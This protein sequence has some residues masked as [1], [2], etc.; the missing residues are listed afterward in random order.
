MPKHPRLMKRGSTFWHRAAVPADIRG[1]YPKTEE[2]FSLKTKDPRAAL[3]LVRKAAAEVDERFASHRR[4]LTR[5]DAQPVSELTAAQVA[6]IEELYFAHLLDEDDEVRLEGFYEKDGLLPEDP[7]PSFEG[8]AEG[9][10]EFGQD[11]RFMIARGK[12]DVSYR[13]EVEEVLGWDGLEIKLEPASSSWKLATRALQA[14]IVRAQEVIA[15]R[16]VGDLVP[17]P[18]VEPAAPKAAANHHLG[19]IMASAVRDEWLAEKSKVRWV[20]KTLH[21]HEVWTQHFLALVGDR[22]IDSYGKADGRAFRQALQRLPANWSKNPSLRGLPFPQ[23]VARAGELSLPPMS[24]KNINKLMQFVGSMWIWAE[25][26]YDEVTASPFKGQSIEITARAR[27]ERDPFSTDQLNKIFSPRNHPGALDR[28]GRTSRSTVVS[29]G[30]RYWVPL[31]SMFSG[32]RLGEV[33]QLR[34]DD[35][36]EE[37]GIRYLAL[38]DEADDQRLKNENARRFIPIHPVLIE[39]GFLDVVA[40][41]KRSGVVRLFPELAMGKDGYY[42]SIFSKAFGRFLVSIDAKTDKTSFH[43]FRHNFEDACRAAGVPEAV[44]NALQGHGESG[45][46]GRYGKGFD[47]KTLDEWMRKVSYKSFKVS[48]LRP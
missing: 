5:A 37:D 20:A 2:T 1:S 48:D 7:V 24:D 35:V 11:A 23:A 8:Y 38:V 4:Q 45:M 36:R 10:H 44:M 40:A 28:R 43:S 42:S 27:E 30:G 34:S 16:N 14:A 12:S 22:P 46:A 31:I 3:V 19:A 39:L 25:R 17:T 15:A 33:V 41:R 26:H 29:S 18:A 9:M 13:S 32:A 21:E 6:R 47:L